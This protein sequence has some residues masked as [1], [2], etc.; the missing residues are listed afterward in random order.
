[1][2][3]GDEWGSGP[4]PVGVWVPQRLVQETAILWNEFGSGDQ[5]WPVV[6]GVGPPEDAPLDN[7]RY[8][9]GPA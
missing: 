2:S 5:Q 4:L 1:M 7:L 9:N 8:L 3:V 6:T